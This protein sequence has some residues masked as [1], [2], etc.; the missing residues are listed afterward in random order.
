MGFILAQIFGIIALALI[1]IGYF[2]KK[3]SSFL[4][5]QI[6]ANIFYAGAFA[7]VGA[8]VGAGLTMISTIRCVYLYI[9]EKREFKY[10]L[11]LLPIFVIAYI[12][13]T[14]IFWNSP[15]DIMPLIT[16]TMFTIGFA[17]KDLQKMRYFLLIPY[18]ILV[19]YN[20]LVSTY[21]SALLDLLE[22]IVI[23]VA[24][25]RFYCLNKKQ[26]SNNEVR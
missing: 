13:T 1:C 23:I 11:H 22:V 3:K 8:F 21:T 19:V 20:I 16:S 17:F 5:I 18:A 10:R 15:Y 24:I 6:V 9:A 2:L 12:I 7:V 26:T 14:I 4:I 25:I